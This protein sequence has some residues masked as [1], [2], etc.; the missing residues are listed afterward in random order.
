MSTGGGGGIVQKAQAQLSAFG[1]QA[2]AD[3][4][5]FC[6]WMFPYNINSALIDS[7]TTGTG[8]VSHAS[9]FATVA[10]GTGTTGEASINTRRFLR[11]EP[12]VGGR[13]LFTAIFTEGVAQSKQTI[14]L[15]DTEDGYF[16]GYSGATFGVFR[17]I[18]GADHFISDFNVGMFPGFDPTKLNV[19][20]ITFQWLGAGEIVFS[21]ENPATGA[22]EPFHKIRFSNS[23]T[24][25]TIRNP[26]L[27]LFAHVKNA[28]NNTDVSLKTASGTAGLDGE[29]DSGALTLTRAVKGALENAGSSLTPIISIQN[30]TTYQT[31]ANRLTVRPAL[32]SVSSIGNT[33]AADFELILNPTLTGASFTDAD[34]GVV[35]VQSDTSATAYSGGDVLTGLTIGVDTGDLIDLAAFKLRLQPGEILTIV[36]SGTNTPDLTAILTFVSEV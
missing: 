6:G 4:N 26:S 25:V 24:D 9:S 27:P 33:G 12:G 17:R 14:G 2:V 10:T 8:S 19:Y 1:R 29:L 15:G 35:P 32:L 23:A 22:L 18:A 28:G 16:I 13:V 21:A 34:S 30:P 20:Q 7:T 5:A 36:G 31:I 3:Y 11:Y